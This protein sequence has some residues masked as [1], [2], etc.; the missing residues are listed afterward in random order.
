MELICYLS[1]GYPTIENSNN[2]AL[3]YANAGC[4]IIEIDFPSRDP[5]LE[6]EYLA[7]RM[8][9]ALEV[10]SDYTKYMQA[11]ADLKK[12]LPATKF[13]LLI[14]EDT[15]EEIGLECFLDFCK[16][17]DFKELIFVGLKNESNKDKLISEGLHVSCYVQYHLLP[18]EVEHA[19]RSNGFVYLQA[20]PTTGNI[21]P[22][23]P[24]LKDCISYLRKEGINRP[25]YCGVGVHTLQ[26]VE[27]VKQANADGVFI[28]SAILKLHDNIP[29]LEKTIAEF[30]KK[31]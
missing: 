21:N 30:K 6:S 26:D 4:D 17:N 15:L 25:I 18:Q 9:K 28:G 23:Y 12:S 13:I 1:N 24:E 2:I 10:C 31:C 29:E 27:I 8:E 20:K 22:K 11:M 16:E 5:Y 14:Y 7:K 3:A 19:K